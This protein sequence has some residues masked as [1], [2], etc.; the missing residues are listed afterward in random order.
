MKITAHDPHGF[1]R[2]R[3]ARSRRSSRE[4][5]SFDALLAAADAIQP[6]A[7]P[8][9]RAEVDATAHELACAKAAQREPGA[10]DGA[11]TYHRPGAE[12]GPAHCRAAEAL[13][14]AVV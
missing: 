4:A 1:A 8:D 2:S 13:V 5:R 6:G 7:V 14:A 3:S 11:L 10:A 9:A 12:A